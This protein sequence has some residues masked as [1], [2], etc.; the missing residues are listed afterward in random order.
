MEENGET[1]ARVHWTPD[2]AEQNPGA[3]SAAWLSAGQPGN[4]SRAQ[5]IR[6]LL[7][8]YQL[9]AVAKATSI[10]LED[11]QG[12]A[13]DSKYLQ[14]RALDVLHDALI[15]EKFRPLLPQDEYFHRKDHGISTSLPGT[16][17][18]DRHERRSSRTP[19]RP[20]PGPGPR[21]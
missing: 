18:P 21:R 7:S 8:G 9:E 20:D 19:Q 15:D 11:L 17:A 5:Y 14:M 3:N 4:M 12:F 13:D 10:P 6:H 2:N 16:F 1:A